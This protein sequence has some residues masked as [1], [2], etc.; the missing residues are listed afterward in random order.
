M[1]GPYQP[2]NLPV[3]LGL[4][5]AAQE[6]LLGRGVQLLCRMDR[7]FFEGSLDTVFEPK[8]EKLLQALQTKNESAVE[9]LMSM[10]SRIVEYGDDGE[11]PMIGLFNRVLEADSPL[12]KVEAV[13]DVGQD[14]WDAMVKKIKILLEAEDENELYEV[15]RMAP[16]SNWK[17]ACHVRS[18]VVPLV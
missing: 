8:R 17:D 6:T 3:I 15:Y 16:W 4:R 18:L 1:H 7:M 11:T 10:M 14:G 12:I 13:K 2:E 9:T 5:N